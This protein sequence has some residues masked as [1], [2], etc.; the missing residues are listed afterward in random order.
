MPP[1]L[2]AKTPSRTDPE[3]KRMIAEARQRLFPE[4]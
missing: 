2:E 4:K 1:G 3:L